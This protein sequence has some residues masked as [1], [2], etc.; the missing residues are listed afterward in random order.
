MGWLNFPA[1][2][3]ISCVRTLRILLRT[4]TLRKPIVNIESESA[5]E[6]AEIF[7]EAIHVMRSKL[8]TVYKAAKKLKD[9]MDI[10]M[11]ES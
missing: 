2:G 3:T 6:P 11:A 4:L 5:Y 1:F 7:L 9:D 10:V 8:G